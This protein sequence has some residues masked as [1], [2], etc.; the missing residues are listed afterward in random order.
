MRF[1]F[2]LLLTAI[3]LSA[4]S[5]L[6]AAI[7][8]E[9]VGDPVDG[10]SWSQAW[11]LQ[12]GDSHSNI[13]FISFHVETDNAEFKHKV[14]VGQFS[15]DTTGTW[16]ESY[17]STSQ[18]T[19]TGDWL[20]KTLDLRVYFEGNRDELCAPVKLAMYLY[21]YGKEKARQKISLKYELNC[22]WVTKIETDCCRCRDEEPS[23]APPASVPEPATLAIWSML[24]GLGL[25]AARRRRR[26]A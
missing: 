21:E 2:P 7:G 24:G 15:S 22:D 12:C 6:Q 8:I 19:A 3:L 23:G 20:W 1:S 9:S 18:A 4:A 26:A 16:C 13:D 5:P 10:N 17:R 11:R 25:I 14:A